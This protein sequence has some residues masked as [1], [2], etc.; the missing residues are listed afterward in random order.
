M[1]RKYLIILNI[2][3]LVSILFIFVLGPYYSN[4]S[5]ENVESVNPNPII[6]SYPNLNFSSQQNYELLAPTFLDWYSI[7]VVNFTSTQP[8]YVLVTENSPLPLYEKSTFGVESG[9]LIY[10]IIEPS[11]YTASIEGISGTAGAIVAVYTSTVVRNKPYELW[12]QIMTYG[13]IGLLIF[14]IAVLAISWLRKE[15]AQPKQPLKTPIAK[16]IEKKR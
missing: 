15:P 2:L 7:V 5:L 1:K 13:G 10:H 14:S 3:Y 6:K 4:F 9:T 16:K 8:V 11:Y 12:G